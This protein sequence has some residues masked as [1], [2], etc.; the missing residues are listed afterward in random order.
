MSAKFPDVF[1][2]ELLS[3]FIRHSSQGCCLG[4]RPHHP[5]RTLGPPWEPPRLPC[6]RS[7]SRLLRS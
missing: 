2:Y 6:L 1:G 4:S 7:F 3:E 5:W